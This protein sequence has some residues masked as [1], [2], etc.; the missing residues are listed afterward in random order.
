MKTIEINSLNKVDSEEVQ[1]LNGKECAE[2]LGGI[3]LKPYGI[4]LAKLGGSLV[5][6]VATSLFGN[7]LGVA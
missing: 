7:L 6:N 1:E 2:T 4:E 5:G 3:D